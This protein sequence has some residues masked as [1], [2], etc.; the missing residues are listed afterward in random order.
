MKDRL[1]RI[2]GLAMAAVC[3]WTANGAQ[4]NLIYFD[5]GDYGQAVEANV[6]VTLTLISPN[7]RVE[8][9]IFIRRDAMTAAT[10]ANGRAFFT[11]LLWGYYRADVAGR[12]GTTFYLNVWTNTTG[13]VNAGTLRTNAAALPPDPSTNYYTMNQIDLLIEGID[14]SGVSSNDVTLISAEEARKATNAIDAGSLTG[15]LDDDRLSANI[16]RVDLVVTR[17]DGVST[18]QTLWTAN[19]SGGAGVI[20][21]QIGDAFAFANHAT[22]LLLAVT[23]HTVAFY[24]NAHFFQ[25]V[26]ITNGILYLGNGAQAVIVSNT[27][28]AT[29]FTKNGEK[30]MELQSDKVGVDKPINS[31]TPA[32]NTFA[33]T[34]VATQFVGGNFIG[35][36]AGLT[37]LPDSF[38]TNSP[39]AYATTAGHVTNSVPFAFPTKLLFVGDSLTSLASPPSW[40]FTLTNLFTLNNVVGWDNDAVSGW[41]LTNLWDDF[42]TSIRAAAHLPSGTTQAVCFVMIGANDL[43]HG[44]ATNMSMATNWTESLTLYVDAI[45][46]NGY[47]VCLFTLTPVSYVE[48]AA[49]G[50]E[51]WSYIN[52]Q[53][54]R[55]TNADWIVRADVVLPFGGD[56][57]FFYDGVHTTNSGSRALATAVFDALS[58]EPPY[59]PTLPRSQRE[60]LA[61]TGLKANP[62]FIGTATVADLTGSG[63]FRFGPNALTNFSYNFGDGI[64]WFNNTIFGGMV[65]TASY[66]TFNGLGYQVP[67]IGYTAPG[68]GSNNPTLWFRTGSDY[69]TNSLNVD[70]LGNLAV[71]GAL[72]VTGGVTA[73]SFTG[74]GAGLTDLPDAFDTN[75]PVAYATTSGSVTGVVTEATHAVSANYATNAASATL[76]SNAN[77]AILAGAPTNAV[78]TNAVN[79][80]GSVVASAFS[81]DGH[82]LHMP[83]NRVQTMG[84]FGRDALKSWDASVAKRVNGQNTNSTVLFIGDSWT[85]W[86]ITT[87]EVRTNLHLMY[88]DSGN[89]YFGFS[90]YNERPANIT[91]TNAGT[92]V[93]S[94]TNAPGG[95]AA[96]SVDSAAG[97]LSVVAEHATRFTL[98]AHKRV[99]SG[100]I[101][102]SIDGGAWDAV[103][104]AG[105]GMLITNL[106]TGLSGTTS[107]SIALRP[108]SGAE[109]DGVT[110][111][112]LD[113]AVDTTYGARL[114][115]IALSGAPS[116]L[117]AESISSNDFFE[118]VMELNPDTALIA[119][120]VNDRLAFTPD[121]TLANINIIC[122]RLRAV[123]TN[124]D[125]AIMVQSDTDITNAVTTSFY[126]ATAF[127]H[128]ARTNGYA[129]IDLNPLFGTYEEAT[130]RGLMQNYSH[131]NDDG[132]RIIA[133]V[134]TDLFRTPHTDLNPLSLKVGNTPTTV[135]TTAATPIFLDVQGKSRFHADL[136]LLNGITIFQYAPGSINYTFSYVDSLST[137]N[138]KNTANGAA[139]MWWTFDGAYVPAL[140]ITN[141]GSVTIRSN[142]AVGG[143][144]T[145]LGASNYLNGV[146]VTNG[147]V[148]VPGT[149]NVT[150]DA[151]ITGNLTALGTSN[152]VDNLHST[153]GTV[154]TLTVGSITLQKLPDVVT[155]AWTVDTLFPLGTNTTISLG[156]V[157]GGYSGVDYA[158]TNT[159]RYGE[160]TIICTGTLTLT[161]PPGW[162]TSDFADTRTGTNGNIVKVTVEVVPGV[163]TNMAIAQFSKR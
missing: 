10:S 63:K 86:P 130:A 96:T 110:I 44:A 47:R 52:E 65:A 128:Y 75:S 91:H 141:K 154:T 127:S 146:I 17:T 90:K 142:L 29:E 149:L 85:S 135:G 60:W 109:G 14:T 113:V 42:E 27:A 122:Q 18:N 59:R 150:G 95:G 25:D 102:F 36:G 116:S 87:R 97:V 158:P 103:D 72:S 143:N 84:V 134:V 45:K 67:Y 104:T 68:T 12:A 137:W 133:N 49:T 50:F 93:Y 7:P 131:P 30:I 19:P 37:D 123:N 160:Q 138:S 53:I 55:V 3:A 99:G 66:F 98:Y 77:Y 152:R 69:G 106:A 58:H 89:G 118:S 57:D 2:M 88:G 140:V 112:G 39:V 24:T 144:L 15:T 119:L 105:T 159:V 54:A 136:R 62:Q 120:G 153:T 22:R 83:T 108:K 92:W 31:I 132:G 43:T 81:G 79:T 107:H 151:S 64:A 16:A 41:H 9:G 34:L 32:T 125:I 147:G 121:R 26:Y 1:A 162:F 6:N 155:N 124:M 115:N 70:V 161:N 8:D 156:T 111:S 82:G 33:G 117:Y 35:S 5:I 11:N 101:E 28:T 78:L 157:T 114:H 139:Y 13:T 126:Q 71:R 100:V 51:R 61:A 21:G 129:F 148:H 74:S 56:T 80:T 73:A 76:A 163:A 94:T 40:A 46:T 23:P 4:T 145:A 20:G 48:S 38:D